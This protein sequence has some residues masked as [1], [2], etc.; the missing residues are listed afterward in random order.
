MY[1]E[2]PRFTPLLPLVMSKLAAVKPGDRI[3]DM[4]FRDTIKLACIDKKPMMCLSDL[5]HS[6]QGSRPMRE[7]DHPHPFNKL[8]T[9]YYC[10]IDKAWVC[11]NAK[12]DQLVERSEHPHPYEPSFHFKDKYEEYRREKRGMNYKMECEVLQIRLWGLRVVN[13]AHT[14]YYSVAISLF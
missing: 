12:N 4:R 1:Q 3:K 10:L 2:E 7:E 5:V 9:Q 13:I 8:K 6:M 11:L 14:G